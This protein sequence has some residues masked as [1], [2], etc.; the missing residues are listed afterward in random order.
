MMSLPVETAGRKL[1]QAID[2]DVVDDG[3]HERGS[4]LHVV[5]T[6]KEASSSDDSDND[7]ID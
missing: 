4:A 1:A 7:K 5:S 6:R 3:E 2:D